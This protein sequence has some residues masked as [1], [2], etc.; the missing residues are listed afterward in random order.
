MV[1][2]R[3]QGIKV[4]LHG[5]QMMKNMN[6]TLDRFI[7]FVSQLLFKLGDEGWLLKDRCIKNVALTTREG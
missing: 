2:A 7:I 1:G 6:E 4:D 3:F 5:A